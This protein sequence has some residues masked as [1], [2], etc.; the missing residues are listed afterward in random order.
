MGILDWILSWKENVRQNEITSWYC[1]SVN[2]LASILYD[3]YVIC[4]YWGKLGEG[5][6]G[7]QV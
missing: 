6:T 5:Y 7:T 4:Y 1:D 3:G 2:F